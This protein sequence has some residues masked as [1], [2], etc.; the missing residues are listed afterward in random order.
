MEDRHQPVSQGDTFLFGG[1]CSIGCVHGYR[2]RARGYR[3][4]GPAGLERQKMPLSSEMADARCARRR[5]ASPATMTPGDSAARPLSSCK[6]MLEVP[7][8]DTWLSNR[9]LREGRHLV[10]YHLLAVTFTSARGRCSHTALVRGAV[11][12]RSRERYGFEFCRRSISLDVAWQSHSSI[13][14]QTTCWQDVLAT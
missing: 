8:R 7:T 10:V 5:R 3:S 13:A 14:R 12:F 6:P 2:I 9:A 1:S 4:E 11:Y